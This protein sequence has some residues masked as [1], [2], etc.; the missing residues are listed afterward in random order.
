MGCANGSQA[1]RQKTCSPLEDSASTKEILGFICR[2]Y[3]GWGF[4]RQRFKIKDGKSKGERKLFNCK[5]GT[6]QKV[7]S[8]FK[9]ET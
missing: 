7:A 2:V 6:R 5:K 1:S 3:S 9:I 8:S 4:H